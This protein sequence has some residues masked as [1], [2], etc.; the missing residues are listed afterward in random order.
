MTT[1]KIRNGK[2]EVYK[3]TVT[4]ADGDIL[5]VTKYGTVIIID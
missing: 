4:I 1:T 3:G 5:E 2:T